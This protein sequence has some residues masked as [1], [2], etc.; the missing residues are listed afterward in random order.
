M[1]PPNITGPEP[2]ITTMP[3]AQAAPEKARALLTPRFSEH[4]ALANST[5]TA[6][7]A[8]DL[9]DNGLPDLVFGNFG[10]WSLLLLNQGGAE[11]KPIQ[12]GRWK[13]TALAAADFDADGDL[14]L[15]IGNGGEYN[16]L[17]VNRLFE[18]NELAFVRREP[19]FIESRF[20]E[21]QVT[22]L[23][24][25]DFDLD[26]DA[27]LAVLREDQP[28]LLF[29]N[30]NGSFGFI[31][32]FGLGHV[33]GAAWADFNN[34]GVPDLAIAKRNQQ[35][36]IWFSRGEMRYRLFES[37]PAFGAP[38]MA[39]RALAIA[40]FNGDGS[41]DIALANFNQ[42]NQLYLNNGDGSFNQSA[43]FGSGASVAM[44]TA[45]LNLDG[46]V[47]LVVANYNEP[48]F[49]YYNEGN[50]SFVE[51]RLFEPGLVTSLAAADFDSDGD[52]DIVVGRYG[53]PS[54]LLENLLR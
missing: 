10:E 51:R 40:D 28:N 25:A 17:L 19:E 50:A 42:Q 21:N 35:G 3:T 34:D 47:D 12:L 23:A 16:L 20:A 6:L 9:D 39:S 44:L 32:Q 36:E 4:A 27:D 45:D 1:Q 15:A 30:E 43:A 54:T 18:G 11:F 31:E 52:P 8:A 46:L 22:A 26:G 2:N 7:L 29:V 37:L 24:A 33:S 53:Q 38:G 14:D 49:V 41:V 13:T 5:T 48:S